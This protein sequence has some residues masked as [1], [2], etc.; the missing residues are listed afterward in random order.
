[1]PGS[2]NGT[3]P[4]RPGGGFGGNGQA[5]SQLQQANGADFD[6]L[7]VQQM[8]QDEQATADA[9]KTEQSQGSDQ[10]AKTLAQQISTETQNTIT[11]LNGLLS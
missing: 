4:N 2:G 1:M 5:M 9:A 11:Q 10:D 3:R 8:V 7:W 6:K